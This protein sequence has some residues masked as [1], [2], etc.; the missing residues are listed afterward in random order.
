MC[1]VPLSVNVTMIITT[2]DLVD[3]ARQLINRWGQVCRGGT[4]CFFPIYGWYLPFWLV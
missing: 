3:R 1:A 4:L 2:L